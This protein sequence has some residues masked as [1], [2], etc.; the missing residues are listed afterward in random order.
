MPV[1][2]DSLASV[3]GAWAENVCGHGSDVAGRMAFLGEGRANYS[4]IVVMTITE[5]QLLQGSTWCKM[6]H[7]SDSTPQHTLDPVMM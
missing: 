6:V 1:F 2:F 4:Y 5:L 3:G 7:Y